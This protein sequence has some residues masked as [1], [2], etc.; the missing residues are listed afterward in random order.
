[1]NR[2]LGDS[3]PLEEQTSQRSHLIAVAQA[4]LVTILW[5]SSWV[6]IK[7]GLEEIPPLIFAGLRYSIA[8]FILL[9]L[10]GARRER[11]VALKGRT[12]KWW[13][14]LSLYGLIYITATQGTQ[15]LALNYLPAITLS[16][17]LNLTPIF[18][19]AMSIP[20][21]KETPSLTE[22]FFIIVGLVGILI[23]FYPLDFIGVS[24]LGLLIG[25]FSLAANSLSSIIGRAINRAQDTPALLVTGISMSI[26][27]V[28]L[29]VLGFTTEVVT[30]LSLTSW[31]W[32][33]WLA[34][35]NTALAFTLWNK[36][37]RD[38]RAIDTT[39]IN[40]TMMPQIILL[41]I[42]FL[43]EFPDLM[44]WIGLFLLAIGIAAVQV[45]QARKRNEHV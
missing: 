25:I 4:C 29:L 30:P 36:A 11:R 44:G 18:V 2:V 16:L 34:V 38:L 12:K 31:L 6:I 40:S 22:I 33:L 35:L 15:F 41:S 45:L 13:A 23:Y 28:V 14:T 7:F 32:I 24:I 10:I 26:G 21:L 39:L 5:S 37:M 19:L 1:M 43:G 42:V 3:V 9:M 27:S 8:S 17:I 20:W